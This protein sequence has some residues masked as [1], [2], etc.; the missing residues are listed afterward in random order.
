MID[1]LLDDVV[2]TLNRQQVN[3]LSD[4]MEDKGF[5]HDEFRMERVEPGLWDVWAA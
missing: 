4:E 2:L 5:D 3:A 1:A